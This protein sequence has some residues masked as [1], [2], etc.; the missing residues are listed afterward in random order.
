MSD[1]P[2]QPP[3]TP[4][5][6]LLATTRDLTRRVRAAQRGTWFPLL[7]LGAITLAAIPIDRYGP[8][9][10]DSCVATAGGGRVCSIYS[11]WAQVYWPVALVAAYVAITGF[12]LVRSRHRGVGSRI[13]PY[14]IAGIGL[15]LL[16]ALVAWW[17]AQHPAAAQTP[18]AS[19]L[20][21]V[22]SPAGVIGLGLLVLALVERT[23]ALLAVALGLLVIVLVPVDFGWVVAPPSPWSFLPH[24]VITG[25]L[26]LAGALGCA[27]AQR[28][29][30]R[31]R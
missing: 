12:S 18:L 27:A 31:P 5:N 29:A 6:E 1:T 30:G 9:Y 13:R 10:T 16:A 23:W 19:L 15:A 17:A 20:Y 28:L 11:I 3:R 25:G 14:A 26:L 8:R 21:R 24:L 7:V 22:V 2:A 4:P